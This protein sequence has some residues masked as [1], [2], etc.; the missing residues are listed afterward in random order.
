MVF[1]KH[2]DFPFFKCAAI[3]PLLVFK[4]TAYLL[5]QGTFANLDD[6]IFKWLLIVRS[7]NIVVSASILKTK[8]KE[9]SEKI[10]IKGFQ[11]SDGW[12]DRW[13]NRYN[14]SFKMLSGEG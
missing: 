14:V 2:P 12:F 5:K 4:Q 6:L 10:N 11:A 7:R 1:A 3:F 9:L 13:K 8:A